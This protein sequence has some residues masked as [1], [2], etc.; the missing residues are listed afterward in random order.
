MARSNPTSS[1]RVAYDDVVIDTVVQGAGPAI[2]LLPSLGRDGLRDFDATAALLTDSGFQVLRP[3]PRSVRGSSGPMAGLSLRCFARDT[4]EVIEQLAGGRA[5]VVGHAYGHGI[6]CMTAVA[7][8]ALVRGVVLAAA[9]ARDTSERFPEVWATPR[10][11]S[12]TGL[13]PALRLA[14]LRLGFFAELSD[15]SA[16]LGGWYPKVSHMQQQA[17][18]QRSHWWGAGSAPMLEIIPEED[19]FKPRD[20]WG[21]LQAEFGS[22]V[23]VVTIPGASHALFVEQP[24]AVAAAIG[25]WARQLPP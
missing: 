6:A 23:D 2:V 11:A 25:N 22:R 1:E 16:W 20:R 19:P 18:V 13:A 17:D 7:Y 9:A 4:A 14:A 5:V 24:V 21:E 8:P 12:D 15:P 3:Q 10:I